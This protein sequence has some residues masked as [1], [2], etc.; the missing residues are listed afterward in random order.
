MDMFPFQISGLGA[1]TTVTATPLPGM[2]RVDWIY[3]GSAEFFYVQLWRNGTF[4]GNTKV[5]ANLR[6]YSYANEVPT[7]SNKLHFVVYAQVPGSGLKEIGKSIVL[8]ASTTPTPPAHT[9][10]SHGVPSDTEL[11]HTLNDISEAYLGLPLT[12]VMQKEYL[13]KVKQYMGSGTPIN[14]AFDRIADE[15]EKA[16][17]DED[18]GF[19]ESR[20]GNKISSESFDEGDIDPDLLPYVQKTGGASGGTTNLLI[21]GAIAAAGLYLLFG[22]K[23]K[24]KG[25]SGTPKKENT[26]SRKPAKKAQVKGKGSPATKSKK[27]GRMQVVYL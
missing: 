10:Q 13:A 2:V 8:P 26:K 7:D 6:T 5:A 20:T 11:V 22:G 21:Y 4:R 1:A 27:S 25:L 24:G 12:A 3:N 18:I 16:V 9:T 14:Q 17:E 15:F 19:Y 23:K